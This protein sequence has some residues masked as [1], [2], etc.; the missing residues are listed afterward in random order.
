M[1]VN[2]LTLDKV[3]DPT[4]RLEAPLFQRPYVWNQKKNWE[5]LWEA[6]QHIADK[7]VAGVK[8]RPHFLG[9]VVLDQLK[10]STG[11]LYARQII[12]G[13]QRLTTLQIALAAIRD[14]CG[15]SGQE[16]FKKAFTKLTDNDTPLSDDPDDV[17]K[18][19]PTNA[20]RSAFRSV[21]SAGSPGK[22]GRTPAGESG[23]QLIPE[24]YLYFSDAILDWLGGP[25]WEEEYAKRV[26]ALYE[27]LKDQLN[28]VVIDLDQDDDAQEIF[29]TLNALG[30]PLLPTDLVKNFLFHR[31]E[32][33]NLNT[34]KLYD[35]HWEHF[36]SE[37]SFWRKEV[38]QG[39]FKRPRLD[40]F[41]Q[42]YLTLV[43]GEEAVTS[44]LFSSF[45]EYVIAGGR[46]SSEYL[47]EFEAYSGIYK[48]FEEFPKETWA[49]LFFYRLRE[50]D[51]ST[52]F[53]LLLEVFKTHPEPENESELRQICSDLES[54]LI[55]R[56]VCQLTP[57]NYNR[58]FV[59]VIHKLRHQQDFS[60]A[61]IR[62][63]LLEQTVDTSRWP[64]DDEFRT[65][66]MT[67]SFYGKH[68][69]T[70]VI[71][72][73]LDAA[74]QTEKTEKIAIKEKLTIE[75]LMPRHWEHY[76]PLPSESDPDTRN[77]FLHKIG[78]LTLLTRRL[79]PAVSNAAW[80]VK[81]KEIIKHSAIALNRQFHEFPEWNEGLIS[82]RTEEL[83]V[84]AN[85]IWPRPDA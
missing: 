31:A 74:S 55:R 17:F 83:L 68:R 79:N 24:A 12:D 59:D 77:S 26:R 28:L 16:N 82:A 1:D 8:V 4:V 44:Q 50:L 7:R 2:K 66:W 37:R 73:A 47:E 21:M 41:L 42:H 84:L 70:R 27:T 53:P 46:S 18:V 71:L 14:L 61:A 81:R 65:A 29:Q 62:S 30:T 58:F 56:A 57:K 76:W 22:V 38:G 9:T 78:N 49:G 33:E 13:Q 54:F 64:N 85:Q 5:P 39:R 48:S 80:N 72:E 60:A 35:L 63:I 40:W 52:V 20:D 51:T 25:P 23:E 15:V 3:F 75:H 19:W 32:G 36:D 10:T 69:R 67:T 6:I 43:M 34:E 45:R 11:S